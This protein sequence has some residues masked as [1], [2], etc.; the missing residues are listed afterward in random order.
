[1]TAQSYSSSA[2]YAPLK[3]EESPDDDTASGTAAVCD[4][5]GLHFD[6]ESLLSSENLAN[7]FNQSKSNGT[8]ITIFVSMID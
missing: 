6:E 8:Y 4:S 5:N 3:N 1:M 7:P 2:T